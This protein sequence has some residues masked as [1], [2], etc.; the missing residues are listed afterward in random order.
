MA[1]TTS[2]SGG[3]PRR[4]SRRRRAATASGSRTSRSAT[5]RTSTS[6]SRRSADGYADGSLELGKL[7]AT[8]GAFGYDLPAGTD[9]ADFASA[10]IWCKQFSHLFATA[11]F[12]DA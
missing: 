6:T 8:D 1:R 4:S 3:A 12:D 9:P 10:I 11:P 7:K 2:T 5:A